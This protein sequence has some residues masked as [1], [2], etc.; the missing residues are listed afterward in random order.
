MD[1]WG[2]GDSYSTLVDPTDPNTIYYEH[3]FGR[4]RRKNM[5]DG[6]LK[7][8]MPEAEIGEPFLR[9]NWMTPF[10]ISHY[11][12]FTLYFGANKLFKSVD[13]GDTWESISPDLSTNPG[14]EKQG[15][16]AFGTLTTISEST[17]RKGL[18]YVGTDDGNVQVTKDEGMS[19]DLV[20]AGLPQKWVSRVVAS[21]YDPGVIQL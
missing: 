21:R 9:Y 15:D 4:I 19:W 20:N 14:P 5:L 7:N 17:L 6:S 10:I 3:Q 13:R 2:G 8:I 18:L 11:N 16:V 12:P 1:R